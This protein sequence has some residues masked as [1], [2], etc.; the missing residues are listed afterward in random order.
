MMLLRMC[1]LWRGVA[2]VTHQEVILTCVGLFGVWMMA[3]LDDQLC[4]NISS[5]F[6]SAPSGRRKPLS[7]QQRWAR[8]KQRAEERKLSSAPEKAEPSSKQMRLQEAETEAP[9]PEDL[10]APPPEPTDRGAQQ[11]QQ[12]KKKKKKKDGVTEAGRSSIRTSSLFKHNPDIPE[13]VSSTVSQLKEKIFTSDSFSELELHPHLVATLN[14]D[15]NVSTLTSVQKQTIPVLLSGRD[16]VVR[17][18][19]GSG[20]TLSYAVPLVHSLQLVRPKVSRSDGPMAVIIVPTRELAQQTLQIFQKLL[21]PFT[22]I[23]PGVLMGGE[24]RKSEKARLRK[25]I[26]VLVSTPGRLVDHIRNTL[27]IVF[28]SVRWLILD[29]ADRTLDLGFEKDVT[30]ILN[31]LNSTGPSRQNVLLSATLSHGVTHLADVCLNDPVSIHVSGP[32]SS[33]LTTINTGTSDPSPASQSESFALP[34]ALQQFV[35]VVPSKIRLVCLAAFIMNKCQLSQNNKLIVFASSC[36]VVDFLHCLFTSVLSGPSA[37]KRPPLSFL[38]LHGNLKQEE[39]SE[40][41]QQFSLSKSG[42]LLCTDVAARGLD[43]PQVTWI[44]QF[45]PPSA[46]AEY[47]HRVGRTARIGGQGSSLLFLTPAET[48]FIDELANHNISL[49]EMK[50]LDILSSLMMD[51]AYKGRGKYHSKT[52]SRALEQEIRER[53]TVLQTHFENFVHADAESLQNAKKALQSFLRAYTTY[54]AHLKHIFHIRSLH[55]GHAA[56]SFGLRDAPQSLCSGASGPRNKNKRQA[57]SPERNQERNQKKKTGGSGAAG[58][59]ERRFR[60]GQR[61]VLMLHSEFSSGLDEQDAKK[62]KKRRKTIGQ[63]GEEEELE[64]P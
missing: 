24:K 32:A 31:S 21:K 2:R 28:S 22:W 57:R 4:L 5:S 16:A 36:E 56:K 20:K 14:K 64:C 15:L 23:V 9:P 58:R 29:E 45:T 46:A 27:S 12:K 6:P 34:E 10:L 35:V 38:R 42:V 50:L 52:S 11:Q 53:A 47:V 44:V 59:A 54:P 41:F 43:L 62:K 49:S 39:R 18:Q 25:G 8:K 1:G 13:I 19:T 55:L 51:D 60:P 61:D 40:V 37:N 3:S 63:S 33:E 26:N 30:V 7:T 17:S 48:A